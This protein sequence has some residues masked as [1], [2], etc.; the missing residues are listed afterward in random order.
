MAWLDNSNGANIN[1]A[2]GELQ[3]AYKVNVPNW[4]Q[5]LINLTTRSIKG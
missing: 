4:I 2:W 5:A 1:Q 3:K